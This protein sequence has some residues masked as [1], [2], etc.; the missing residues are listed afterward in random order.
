MSAAVGSIRSFWVRMPKSVRR[1]VL[2][3]VVADALLLGFIWRQAA[4]SGASFADE[5]ARKLQDLY[6]GLR[7]AGTACPAPGSAADRHPVST[8]RTRQYRSSPYP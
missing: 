6:P 1:R 2:F 3:L 7:I 8:W 5:A 4:V